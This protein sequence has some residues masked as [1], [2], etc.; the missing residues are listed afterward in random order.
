MD[1]DL[2]SYKKDASAVFK[3]FKSLCKKQST[4]QL[5]VLHIDEE[6][7]IYEKT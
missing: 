2:L 6:E 7:R 3:N 1:I 5:K 4:C